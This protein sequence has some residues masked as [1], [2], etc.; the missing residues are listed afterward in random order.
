MGEA[1]GKRLG[2]GL[3][4]TLG[5]TLDRPPGRLEWRLGRRRSLARTASALRLRGPERRY[6]LVQPR[7]GL[8]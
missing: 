3:A 5:K 8:V 2:K 7:L 4:K 1:L 6:R